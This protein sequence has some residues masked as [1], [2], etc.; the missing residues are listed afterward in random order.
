MLTRIISG[1]VGITLATAII[2][3]GGVPY[4]VAV[5]LLALIGWREYTAAFHHKG[6]KLLSAAGYISIIILLLGGLSGDLSHLGIHLTVVTFILLLALVYLHGKISAEGVAF[7]VMGVFY[8]G[9]GFL[10][11]LLLRNFAPDTSV[12]TFAGEMTLGCAF[13]WIMFLGTWS[14][15]TFAYFTGY[16][17]GR[18]K[19]S[20]EISP[21]KTIEGF[22]GGLV[23]TTAVVTA[24]GVH[25]GMAA[26]LMAGLGAAVCILATLGDLVESVIKR[27]TGIK[28][29]GN[30]IPGH[31]GILDRF[32]SVIFTAPLVYWFLILVR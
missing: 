16:F 20:P 18:H 32:D 21:K 24:L 22:I 25:L 7:S 23:G 13:L 3:Y 4:A 11:L 10:H 29:S 9:W 5:F 12:Q 2:Q 28:D 27:Y 15:D 19:M 8:I 31:G 14:S 17:F 26:W 30:I 1:V 6:L